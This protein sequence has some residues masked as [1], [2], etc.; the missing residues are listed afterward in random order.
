[1]AAPAALGPSGPSRERQFIDG[2]QADLMHL[3]AEAK[4]KMLNVKLV[5][6][7]HAEA[8]TNCTTTRT[9]CLTSQGR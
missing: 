2:M 6:V 5:S 1:M 3:S 4:K 8:C 9:H 7:I